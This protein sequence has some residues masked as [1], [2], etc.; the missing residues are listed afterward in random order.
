MACIEQESSANGKVR[1]RQPWYIGL[2]KMRS[3]TS[4]REN[5]N[6]GLYCLR[7]SKVTDLVPIENAYAT[8]YWSLVVTLVTSRTV[9]DRPL[10]DVP[11]RGTPGNRLEYPHSLYVIFLETN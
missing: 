2:S 5:L 4:L 10:F 3:S 9:F 1:A 8:S 6:L 7:S 11:P